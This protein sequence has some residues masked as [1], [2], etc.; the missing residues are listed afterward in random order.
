MVVR[1][2]SR[3]ARSLGEMISS[4]SFYAVGIYFVLDTQ[5][6]RDEG[7]ST[8]KWALL[9]LAGVSCILAGARFVIADMVTR[10]R[11]AKK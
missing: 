10:M 7:A 4:V 11:K 8:I 3:K 9:G 1:T 6:I 5:L 2:R